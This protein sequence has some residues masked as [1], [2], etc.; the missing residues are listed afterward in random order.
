MKAVYNLSEPI[1]RRPVSK[2]L[3]G[4]VTRDH[5]ARNHVHPGEP[6]WSPLL[7][8]LSPAALRPGTGNRVRR[9]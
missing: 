3:T 2:L 8:S 4:R 7:R 6:A 9:G 1:T 5:L